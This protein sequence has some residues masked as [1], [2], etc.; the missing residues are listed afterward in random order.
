VMYRHELA[1]RTHFVLLDRC[2]CPLNVVDGSTAPGV[3]SAMYWFA[4]GNAAQMLKW[5]RQGRTVVHV[6]HSAYIR[7]YATLT[8]CTH[9]GVS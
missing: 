9:G 3:D 4:G 8:P 1:S 2:G 6:S 5:K 7:A